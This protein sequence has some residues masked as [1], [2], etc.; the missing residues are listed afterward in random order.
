MSSISFLDY[1]KD[2]LGDLLLD[3]LM[4][5]PT[6]AY[7][8][9]KREEILEVSK[10]LENMTKHISTIVGIDTGTNFQLKYHFSLPYEQQQF[11]LAVEIRI[12]YDEAQVTSIS[13]IFP[14]ALFNELEIQEMFGIQFL[15]ASPR[16]SFLLPD[17]FPDLHPLRK[18]VSVEDLV[19]ED[20]DTS[21]HDSKDKKKKEP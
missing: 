9:I 6:L 19:D 10:I 21:Y 1:L 20:Q 15:G 8:T 16:A 3:G 17:A 4:S 14:G 18:S 11:S 7:I 13:S 12:P 2:L 5:R